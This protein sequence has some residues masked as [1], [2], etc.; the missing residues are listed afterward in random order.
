MLKTEQSSLLS[1][2]LQRLSR[3]WRTPKLPNPTP[4]TPTHKQRAGVRERQLVP[5]CSPDNFQSPGQ[6]PEKQASDRRGPEVRGPKEAGIVAAHTTLTPST[7]AS[8]RGQKLA[9]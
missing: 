4:T 2:P 1:A 7:G 6:L 9:A 5:L 3:D 8:T